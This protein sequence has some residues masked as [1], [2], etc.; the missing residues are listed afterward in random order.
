MNF[1]KLIFRLSAALL[2]GLAWAGS[3]RADIVVVSGNVPQVDENV[4][5]NTGSTG[6]PIF[7]LTNMT[8]LS[9]RFTGQE[10]LTA[11]A[12]GQ[13]RVTAATGTFNNLTIDLSSA[14]S[15]AATG[16]FTSLILNPDAVADGTLTITVTEDNG[17]VNT[18]SLLALSGSG[19]NFFTIT[20]VA[21]QRIRSVNIASNVELADVAQVRIGGAQQQQQPIPE[22]MTMLLLGTGLAGVAAKVR[23]HRKGAA[24]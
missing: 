6:N 20:A 24:E 13:A 14:T 4:L 16:T 5:L 2:V 23:R 17:M 7:G 3:A 22:P 15:G 12:N 10:T 8:Q 21:G 18:F 1:K 19:Q 9:V 11:P